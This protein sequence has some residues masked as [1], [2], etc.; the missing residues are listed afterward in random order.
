VSPPFL[1]PVVRT[2]VTPLRYG[3]RDAADHL[4]FLVGAGLPLNRTSDFW[5]ATPLP[6]GAAMGLLD[7]DWY[8]LARHPLPS[9][10]SVA[11]FTKPIPDGLV[12]AHL[13]RNGFP[14]SGIVRGQGFF[15]GAPTTIVFQRLEHFPLTLFVTTPAANLQATW[16]ALTWPTYVLMLALFACGIAMIQWTGRQQATREREREL[17]MAEMTDLTLQLESRNA[18]LQGTNAA[19]E[20]A[21]AEL[22]AFTYTVSHDLRAPIRAIDGFAAVLAD[23]LAGS[24]QSEVPKL[25]ERIRGNT[26]RMNALLDDLLDLSRYSKLDIKSEPIDMQLMVASVIEELGMEPNAHGFEVGEMPGCH[27]D[28]VLI[29]QVWSNLLG[30]AVKYSAKNPQPQVRVGFED[31]KYYVA[32]NGAGFDMTYVN[33]LFKVFSRLHREAE[34]KGTGV[35]LA[36][37]KRIVARHGGQIGAIGEV[38]KGAKFWFSLR[39]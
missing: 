2:W 32:D 19:M 17:R 7:D 21:N 20:A 11:G 38:G 6:P 28:S 16:W 30:N 9:G 39:A 4:L 34:F 37:V 14:A 3:V 22:E 35:G 13:R 26:S 36:I 27:G 31:D 12:A 33:K 15:S 23:D 25:L 5:N 18:E 24:D 10:M 29:R 1:G 8:L